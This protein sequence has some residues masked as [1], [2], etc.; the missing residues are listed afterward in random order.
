[1]HVN[2]DQIHLAKTHE[3]R[4]TITK[5]QKQIPYRPLHHQMFII[6]ILLHYI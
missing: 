3:I 6:K 1:M 2:S 4:D 5:L